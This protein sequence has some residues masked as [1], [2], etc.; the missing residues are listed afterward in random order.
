MQ[1]NQ[2]AQAGPD[3]NY[4]YFTTGNEAANTKLMEEQPDEARGDEQHDLVC[5]PC[6]NGLTVI[7]GWYTDVKQER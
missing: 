7:L 2:V 4:Q 1:G 5:P 6:R 3:R